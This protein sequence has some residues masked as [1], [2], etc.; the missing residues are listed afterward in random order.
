MSTNNEYD[1]AIVG[2]GVSGIYT[3]WRLATADLN[4]S[5]LLKNW[6]KDGNLKIAVF[7]GSDRIGGR[8]LSAKAPGLPDIVCEI[9]G[10]RYV[11]P[12]Q[13]I[14][15]SLVENELKLER[16]P[17]NV[18]EPHNLVYS[19]GHRLHVDDLGDSEKLPYALR[20][21][22]REWL[23]SDSKNTADNFMGWAVEKLIPGVKGKSGEEL[24]HFLQ[25]V[26]IDGTPLYQHGFWNL[27][28]QAISNEAY[29]VARSTIGYD[30]LGMNAN[31]VDLTAEYFDFNP[32][33]KYFLLKDGYDVVPF[34]LFQRFTDAGGD[35]HLN[36]WLKGFDSKSLSDGSKGAE[37]SFYNNKPNVS[38]RAIVL[39][40]PR[41]SLELLD[42][43]GPVMNHPDMIRMMNAVDPVDLYKMFI[44]YDE[45]W[46][47]K[48]YSN[49]TTGRSLTDLPL[50]Q[51]YYWGDESTTG[52]NPNNKNSI[53]M[54]YND[55]QSSMFWGGL[56]SAP[57]G[58]GD[59]IRWD[60]PGAKRM[61]Q[62]RPSISNLF[63]RKPM[64][65]HDDS[66]HN[67]WNKQLR[68]NWDTHEAPHAMVKEM[69]KQLIEIHGADPKLVP[70]PMEAAFM[71]WGD[72]P[73][74]GAVHFWN[75]GYKS[76]EVLESMTQPVSDVNCFVC[77][78]AFS[79][80]QTWVEGALQTA[81]IVLQKR[82]KLP[83]PGWISK[84]KR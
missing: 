82:L 81:E 60:H 10:M 42:R 67:D 28:A 71:D 64:R 35:V 70:E 84:P 8:L 4:Q 44:A 9:G 79:T 13:Y 11:S 5:P 50:R 63:K 61:S 33:V 26:E 27:V 37:L 49:L 52:K 14:I 23:N 32:G 57:L 15:K 39:A 29:D 80:N 45:A 7:E 68:K 72:D 1:I 19:R 78:E 36:S 74:G 56:R 73:Y 53:I 69:H 34:T 31:A 41:R 55:M 22:E 66:I 25:T 75:P 59:E 51:C 54:A 48:L 65:H 83:E 58:P 40:M 12:T 46:W 6:A 77:G 2:G 24:A 62:R 16:F 18:Y 17:Q 21:I 76:W 30:A 47:T 20:S 43:T 3:A 38:A